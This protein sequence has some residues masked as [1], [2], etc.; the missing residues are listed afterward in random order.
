MIYAKRINIEWSSDEDY[1]NK[2]TNEE[3]KINEIDHFKRSSNVNQQ[4]SD[5]QQPC[6]VDNSTYFN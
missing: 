6:E 4:S 3:L 5:S 2:D 1:N